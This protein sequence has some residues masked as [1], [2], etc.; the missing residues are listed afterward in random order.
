[1]LSLAL[2][3]GYSGSVKRCRQLSRTSFSPYERVG[4]HHCGASGCLASGNSGG[5]SAAADF[6][7]E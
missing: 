5:K 4:E 7:V 2:E 6:A 1:M 3:S